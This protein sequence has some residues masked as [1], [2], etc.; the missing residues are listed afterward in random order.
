MRAQRDLARPVGPL[1]FAGEASHFLGA[2]GT[3]HGAL[4]TGVRAARE[5]L[6]G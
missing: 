5:I 4:E 6:A 3:V 1:H 2:C